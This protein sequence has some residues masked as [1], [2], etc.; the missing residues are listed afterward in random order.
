MNE[1][2][3]AIDA[4]LAVKPT[5][6]VTVGRVHGE[7]GKR[8]WTATTD[9]VWFIGSGATPQEAVEDYFRRDKSTLTGRLEKARA[10]LA[11]LEKQEANV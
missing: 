5:Q 3:Q 4:L 9:D 10:E 2:E 1:I 8:Y 6:R 11:A 7:H